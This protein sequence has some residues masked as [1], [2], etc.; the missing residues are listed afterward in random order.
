MDPTIQRELDKLDPSI[1]FRAATSHHHHTWART[2]HSRPELYIRPQSTAE[3]QKIVTLAR[4]CRRRITLVGCGHSPSDLTCT[5]SWMVNLDSYNAVLSVDESSGIV[6]MQAGIRLYDL[7]AELSKHD[8]CMPNLGSID[9]QAIAGALATAT[10]G[11]STQHG[12]LSESVLALRIVLANG[13]SV[14][15]SGNQ[16]PSLFRAA[17]VSLGALGIITEVTFRAVPTFNIAWSQTLQPMSHVLSTWTTSL[18]TQ[19][20][21]VRVWW[22]PYMQSAIV[23]TANRTHDPA[24]PPAPPARRSLGFH[25]YQLALYISNYLPFLL[26]LIERLVATVQ[27]GLHPSSPS[28]GISPAHKGLLMDCL[29][30]QFVNEW[31]IPLSSGPEAI[32]RLSTFLLSPSNRPNTSNIPISNAKLYVHAP[33]EVRVADTSHPSTAHPRPFLDNTSPTEPTLYL[34]ATLYRPYLTDPPCRE[35]YYAAFEHLMRDL[36]GRPHWAKNFASCDARDF[37]HMYGDDLARWR[38]VR[39]DVDPDG[40]FVGAW[41]RRYVLADADADAEKTARNPLPL[42][43]PEGVWTRDAQGGWLVL[44]ASESRSDG[45]RTFGGGEALNSGQ[46]K[47][48][49]EK[50]SPHEGRKEGKRTESKDEDLLRREHSQESF[51]VVYGGEVEGSVFLQDQEGEG[52]VGDGRS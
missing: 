7:G 1:P 46:R 5:S 36:G 24:P 44:P 15:C 49:N 18:W 51:D 3:I 26:P 47:E 16:N 29:Y 48:P 13:R 38:A 40:L 35:R 34:N 6:V 52:E 22:L 50:G 8:L 43:E 39:D 23:W 11:S 28:T 20:D 9:N 2:F 42:E 30:S 27:Y 19:A 41:H 4:R 21:F 45:G 31:A 14:L 33:I 10:H 32:T 25:A 37:E 17:L 12:L